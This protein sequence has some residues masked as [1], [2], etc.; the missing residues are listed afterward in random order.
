[1]VALCMHEHVH[2]ASVY[3]HIMYMAYIVALPCEDLPPLT[4]LIDNN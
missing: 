1:M 3:S 4:T 2:V